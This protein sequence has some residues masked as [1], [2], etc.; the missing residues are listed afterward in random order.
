[1]TFLERIH[2]TLIGEIFVDVYLVQVNFLHSGC[3]PNIAK[4]VSPDKVNHWKK[5]TNFA[6]Q[7]K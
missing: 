4:L 6:Y 3:F 5:K 2:D 7:S 1:M